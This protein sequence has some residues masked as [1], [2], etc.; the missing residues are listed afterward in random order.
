MMETQRIRQ[1]MQNAAQQGADSPAAPGGASLAQQ[2]R[3]YAG[4]ARRARENCQHGQA[5]EQELH[6]RRNRSG[7]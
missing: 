7:Q 5:A 6:K 4:V 2:S 3:G 1:T